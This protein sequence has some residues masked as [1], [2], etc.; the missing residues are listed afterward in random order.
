MALVG[1]PDSD[2]YEYFE[3]LLFK[4]LMALNKNIQDILSLMRVMSYKSTLACFENFNYCKF[5]ERFKSDLYNSE[6]S[7]LLVA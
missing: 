3:S 6:N 7:H 4:G 1:D 5:V 2:L